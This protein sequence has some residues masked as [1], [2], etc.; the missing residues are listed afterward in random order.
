MYA[1]VEGDVFV[2]LIDPVE[3]AVAIMLGEVNELLNVNVPEDI[4]VAVIDADDNV[5]AVILGLVIELVTVNT[6][7]V[8]LEAFILV[9][10]IDPPTY[11][12]LLIPT[13]PA[14]V[15][16]PE[17]VLSEL[18]VFCIVIVELGP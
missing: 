13:P 6:P 1:I 12:F 18:L 15:N 3:M 17:V 14:T 2:M 4:S 5:V 10:E 16:A 11:K 8:S 7:T 9:V